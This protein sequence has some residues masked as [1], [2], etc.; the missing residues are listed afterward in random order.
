MILTVEDMEQRHSGSSIFNM[1]YKKES[2]VLN[3][4]WNTITVFKGWVCLTFATICTCLLNLI[5]TDTL[6]AHTL[7]N[8]MVIDYITGLMVAAAHK[9]K[10]SK[11]GNLSSSV[12]FEGIVK[13]AGILTVIYLCVRLDMILNI[14]YTAEMVVFF[15]IAN[16]TISILENLGLLGVPYP[17]RLKKALESLNDEEENERC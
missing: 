1:Y 17:K 12:G 2:C 3:E 6:A 8:L 14:E 4:L 5:G 7:I 11:N 9:S 16:E 15:F 13:K 10:K